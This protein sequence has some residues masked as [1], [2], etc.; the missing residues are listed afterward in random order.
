[1][2]RDKFKDDAKKVIDELFK[3]IDDLE[4]KKNN[5]Q[6]SAKAQYEQQIADLKA[7]KEELKKSYNQL[8]DTTEGNWDEAKKSFTQSTEHFKNGLKELTSF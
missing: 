7:K 5:V 8:L 2:N 1:M 4:M 3:K 6:E